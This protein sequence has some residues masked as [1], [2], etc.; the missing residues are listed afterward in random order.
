MSAIDVKTADREKLLKSANDCGL[1][2]SDYQVMIGGVRFN[3]NPNKN[4]EVDD[5]SCNIQ[6]FLD[7]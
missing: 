2:I 5:A 3:L 6:D 4:L 1:K 7:M